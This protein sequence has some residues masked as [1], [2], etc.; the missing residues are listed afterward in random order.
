MIFLSVLLLGPHYAPLAPLQLLWLNLLT[1]SFPALALGRE[2]G[3]P[4]NMQ[5]PPRA[6]DARI[7]DRRMIRTIVFQSIAIF[8]TVY[9]AF[10]IGRL[11]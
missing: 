8:G 5:R 1:D 2:P 9:A 4:D 7:V 10:Q 3:E 11:A 6:R